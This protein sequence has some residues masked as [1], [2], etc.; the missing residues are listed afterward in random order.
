MRE[1]NH[2]RRIVSLLSEGKFVKRS[3]DRVYELVGALGFAFSSRLPNAL[4]SPFLPGW[5]YR[6]NYAVR[7]RDH[8]IART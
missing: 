8:S 6:F 3:E 2:D 5:I 7:V 4:Y 1:Q